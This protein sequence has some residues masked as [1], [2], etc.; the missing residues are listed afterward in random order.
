MESKEMT[1]KKETVMEMSVKGNENA[2]VVNTKEV[3]TDCLTTEVKVDESDE[4][5]NIDVST[6]D[7]DTKKR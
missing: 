6:L 7:L 1:E 2:D 5:F 4:R 3:E